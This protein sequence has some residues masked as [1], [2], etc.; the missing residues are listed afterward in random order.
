[1]ARTPLFARVQEA[2]SVVSEAQARGVP[3]EQVIEER[4]TTRRTFLK[5]AAAVGVAAA[6]VGA[7]GRYSGRARAA[8]ASWSS[9]RGWQG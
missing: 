3:P 6:G 2:A 9:G 5:E 4:R 1:M 7:L 8:R